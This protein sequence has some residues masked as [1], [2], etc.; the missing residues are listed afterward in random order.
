MEETAPGAAGGG[1]ELH[2]HG[3]PGAWVD[4]VEF[5]LGV[6]DMFEGDV[7]EGHFDLDATRVAAAVWV[8][9]GEEFALFAVG[10]FAEE[11]RV[12]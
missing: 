10:E 1:G 6:R 11:G 4:G 8:V 7:G 3:I 12:F 9:G 5:A 2:L